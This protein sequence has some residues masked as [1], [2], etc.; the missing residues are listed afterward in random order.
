MKPALANHKGRRQSSEPIES[1]SNNME[2]TQSAGKRVRRVTVG[3]NFTF[4]WIRSGMSFL[5]QSCGVVDPKAITCQRSNK[6]YCKTFCR[7]SK[8]HIELLPF[9][10]YFFLLFYFYRRN[11]SYRVMFRLTGVYIIRAA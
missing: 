4:D 3:L 8:I 10:F 11:V 5:S 9:I 6:N 2:L 7:Q 1:R